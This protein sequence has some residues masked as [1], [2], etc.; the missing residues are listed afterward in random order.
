[1]SPDT[2]QGPMQDEIDETMAALTP[3]P[4]LGMIR[5]MVDALRASASVPG[6][7]VGEAVPLFTLP[8]ADGTPVALADR[9]AEGPVVLTFYRGGWCPVCNIALRS[10]QERLEEISARGASLVAVSPQ[11]PD[12]SLSSVERMGLGFD[13][14]SD[15]D[16]KVARACRLGFRVSD[17]MI[18]QY[19]AWGLLL[20][21]Q[22]ADGSWDLPVPATFVIDRSGTVR[23]RHVD[24]DYRQRMEPDA[25]LAAL[26]TL[27]G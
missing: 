14:L 26:D 4:L 1:V 22:N 15:L 21:D 27:G 20:P 19:Q 17:E 7:A 3:E 10:L 6:L 8:G 18:A 25:I 16:Q 9:L 12:D 5:R 23:A 2:P 13:V 24:P 11:S